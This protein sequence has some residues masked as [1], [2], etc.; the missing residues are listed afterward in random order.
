MIHIGLYYFGLFSFFCRQLML[1]YILMHVYILSQLVVFWLF[2]LI[3]VKNIAQK[4][5]KPTISKI[6]TL[7]RT[8]SSNLNVY[9]TEHQP[10]QMGYF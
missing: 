7:P 1:L 6:I 8:F 5:L 10:E 4:K 9:E 2:V 3:S